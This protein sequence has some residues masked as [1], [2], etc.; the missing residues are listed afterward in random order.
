LV[1]GFLEL[2]ADALLI[3]LGAGTGDGTLDFFNLA[4]SHDILQPWVLPNHPTTTP[5][6]A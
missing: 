2:E 5:A 6:E 3:D 1:R 4:D